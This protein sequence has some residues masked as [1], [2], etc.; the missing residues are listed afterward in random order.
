MWFGVYNLT[1]I[2]KH[3]PLEDVSALG[4]NLHILDLSLCPIEDVSSLGYCSNLHTLNLSSCLIEDVSA[5]DVT[6]TFWI[7]VPV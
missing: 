2:L 3:C 5:L 4:C 7:L 6:Y 1:L